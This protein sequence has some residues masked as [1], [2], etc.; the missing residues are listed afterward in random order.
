MV[1]KVALAIPPTIGAAIM[2][3]TV[4]VMGLRRIKAPSIMAC[5]TSETAMLASAAR[6]SF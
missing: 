6:L 1:S 2:V 3:T 4:M 5:F